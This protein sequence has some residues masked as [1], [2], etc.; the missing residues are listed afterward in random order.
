MMLE[1]GLK[2]V[3]TELVMGPDLNQALNG[4]GCCNWISLVEDSSTSTSCSL[5]GKKQGI[6]SMLEKQIHVKKIF[7]LS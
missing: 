3:G 2:R 6:G 5:S 7:L 1:L 4:H